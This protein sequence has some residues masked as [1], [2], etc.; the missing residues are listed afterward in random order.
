MGVRMTLEN[1]KLKLESLYPQL[2]LIG[3]YINLSTKTRFKCLE[4]G[5]EF[6]KE[7][8]I[9]FGKNGGGCPR[10]AGRAQYTLEETREKVK[11]EHDNITF[12]P[13]REWKGLKTK[14]KCFCSI[15]NYEWETSANGLYKGSNCPVCSGTKH[16]TTE[17]FKEIVSNEH[18]E[19]EVIGDYVRNSV[20]IAI[21]C[22]NCGDITYKNP[23]N[24]KTFGCQVC[25]RS[26]RLTTEEFKKLLENKNPDVELLGEYS[27]NDVKT[28]FRCKKCT[29]EWNTEPRIITSQLSGC[30]ICGSSKGERL[31]SQWLRSQ[32]IPFQPQM[33]FS[34]CKD[35]QELPF[36]FYI[37]AI[38]ML[39]EFDGP[40]HDAPVQFYGTTKERAEI[41][42][43]YTKKHDNMK[44][45]FCER[46]GY[47]LFRIKYKDLKN[48]DLILADNIL[49]LWNKVK[50]NNEN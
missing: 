38:N 11:L 23:R 43:E 47:F 25:A 36:D 39:I 8:T 49:P 41:V 16:Y 42:F 12:N 6:E 7:P 35:K 40:Q 10:C 30:P 18:P 17:E 26:R 46:E 33:T 20:P 44:N 45:N 31:I 1:F 5:Y 22:K 4:C 27:G 2:V 37:P 15:H 32:K 14:V 48:I 3:D 24:H 13:I 34:G 21:R 29:Y 28:K 50:N 19:L 9:M